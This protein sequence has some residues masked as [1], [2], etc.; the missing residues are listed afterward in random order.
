MSLNGRA[1]HLVMIPVHVTS[2]NPIRPETGNDAVTVNVPSI[3]PAGQPACGVVHERS[4][5]VTQRERCDIALLLELADM[6]HVRT[7]ITEDF[8]LPAQVKAVLTSSMVCRS[9]VHVPHKDAAAV[10]QSIDVRWMKLGGKMR[11]CDGIEDPR[12]IAIMNCMVP[13]D[14]VEVQWGLVDLAQELV[15]RSKSLPFPP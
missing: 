10:C 8:S 3:F 4:S 13:I 12:P 9:E 2:V 14:V 5:Q 1:K 7:E 11:K 6:G 15:A